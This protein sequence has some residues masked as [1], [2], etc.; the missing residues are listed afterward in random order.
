MAL[1][2]FVLM[3]VVGA[4][5]SRNETASVFVLD[6]FNSSKMNLI[7]IAEIAGGVLIT[8]WDFM[9]RLLGTTPLTARQWGLG[10]AAAVALLTLW[11]L[12]KWIARRSGYGELAATRPA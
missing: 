6:T 5:E 11:E 4:F 1:V 9:N 3:L 8:Q 7:A 12:G 2:G 10:L